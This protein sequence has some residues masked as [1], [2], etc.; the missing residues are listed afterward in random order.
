[1]S[2]NGHRPF[3]G[4]RAILVTQHGK[5]A[6]IGPIFRASL[7]LEVAAA[8]GIDT[9]LLGTFSGEIE[10]PGSM[11]EVL[12]RKAELGLE[13]GDYDIAI[14]SEGSYGPNPALPFIG[15]GLEKII[16]IDRISGLVAVE[17]EIELSP[18]F[19]VM[20]GQHGTDIDPFLHRGGFPGHAMIVKPLDPAGPGTQV[21]KGLTDRTALDAAV[22]EA[23]RVSSSGRFRVESDLRAHLNPTRMATIT[24]LAERFAA[25]L[26][27][28]CPGCGSP[29]WGLIATE[30]GLPCSACGEPTA[31]V[32][33]E[34][35]GC[36]VCDCRETRSRP[37]GLA[38]ASP[39][40]CALCNP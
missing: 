19:H 27:N 1:M 3:G 8:R 6:A 37:D 21:F 11:D 5:E 7:G 16:L 25:R 24:R 22:D 4:R 38:E 12:R 31:R 18:S 13:R 23:I 2:A 30:S 32:R 36:F 33:A 17:R 39:G 14:A 34:V 35:F 28:A 40:D 9:D 20:D 26:L 29:G 15:A 10:R